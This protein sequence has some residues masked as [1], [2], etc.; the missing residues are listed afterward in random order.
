M[1]ATP[2]GED[3]EDGERGEVVVVGEFV[4]TS[5]VVWDLNLVR[6]SVAFTEY[7]SKVEFC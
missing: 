7:C 6:L 3:V 1:T 5:A 2:T 4:S